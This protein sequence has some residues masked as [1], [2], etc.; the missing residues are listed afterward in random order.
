MT[1]TLQHDRYLCLICL[2]TGEQLVMKVEAPSLFALHEHLVVD[3]GVP[4]E[5]VM[6]AEPQPST[7]GHG[8]DEQVEEWGLPIARAQT[9]GLPRAAYLRVRR[10]HSQ[11]HNH[12]YFAAA[13]PTRALCRQAE[14]E[15]IDACKRCEPSTSLSGGEAGVG[16]LPLVV[17]V[18]H[19]PGFQPPLALLRS[20]WSTI[21]SAEGRCIPLPA[22]ALSNL[23]LFIRR[24]MLMIRTM[25]PGVRWAEVT[26]RPGAPIRADSP[27]DEKGR[28]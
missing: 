16:D 22:E 13:F 6:L 14:G 8:G 25:D 15:I 4:W 26:Y 17:Y 18:A 27:G 21:H 19:A 1:T 9:L 11:T 28:P 20:I 12:F 7:H 10:A 5:E 3:H 23:L 2:R 24:E